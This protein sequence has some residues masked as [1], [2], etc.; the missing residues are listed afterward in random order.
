MRARL[1]AADD[2]YSQVPYEKGSNLLLHLEGLCP[3]KDV[4]LAY[5][6]EYIDVYAGKAVS[7][8]TWHAHIIGYFREHHPPTACRM[9]RVEWDAWLHGEGDNLPNSVHYDSALVT[10]VRNALRS[11]NQPSATPG[12]PLVAALEPMQQS[13]YTAHCEPPL[14]TVYLLDLVEQRS[15]SV[16]TLD[17][18]AAQHKWRASLNPEIRFRYYRMMLPLQPDLV[19]EA[20]STLDSGARGTC[21]YHRVGPGPRMDAVQPADHA[22]F[23]RIESPSLA[24]NHSRS[25]ICL[26]EGSERNGHYPLTNST[27]L[28]GR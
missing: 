27:Q 8:S 15:Y 24:L 16:G 28:P 4:F 26:C 5:M 2:A 20:A 11:V 17:C 21:A 14:I 9:E 23:G 10:D 12:P 6:R 1:T 22:S 25:R 18:L 7:S 19:E 3:S 13:L